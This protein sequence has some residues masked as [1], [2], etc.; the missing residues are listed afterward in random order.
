M[1]FSTLA[2]GKSNLPFNKDSME[3]SSYEEVELTRS[4]G[5][6]KHKSMARIVVDS[7]NI[8]HILLFKR[9]FETPIILTLQLITDQLKFEYPEK[10]IGGTLQVFFLQAK[11][12][13]ANVWT[14]TIE[15]GLEMTCSEAKFYNL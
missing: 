2:I 13:A 9:Q 15:T 14:D 10:C 7:S 8:Y 12:L 5:F 3:S 6:Q 4:I 11:A 1:K